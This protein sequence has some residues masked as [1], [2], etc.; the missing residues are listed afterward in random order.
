MLDAGLTEF[1][2]EQAL[3]TGSIAI[4]LISD[5]RLVMSNLLVDMRDLEYPSS[6]YLL[7]NSLLVN[8]SLS[9]AQC[10]VIQ[11]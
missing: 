1:V 3:T 11:S 9:K 2:L 6:F 7:I 8:S 4:A 5:R 10:N